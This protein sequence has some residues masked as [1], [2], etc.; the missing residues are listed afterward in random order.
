[1]G[2]LRCVDLVLETLPLLGGLYP[3]GFGL[4]L[5]LGNLVQEGSDLL[6]GLLLGLL[7]RLDLTLKSLFLLACLYLR[8]CGAFLQRSDV[9]LKYYDLSYK[10]R[11]SSTMRRRL[12]QVV[13]KLCNLLAKSQLI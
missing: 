9:S 3:D 7:Q 12:V 4:F 6:A 2:L 8:R 5:E 10:V 13:P 1:M 11:D